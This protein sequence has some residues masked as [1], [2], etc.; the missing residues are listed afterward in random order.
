MTWVINAGE[1][2]EDQEQAFSFAQVIQA[3]SA[4]D[5]SW[6][7]KL[8]LND[9]TSILLENDRFLGVEYNVSG[10]KT[11][12]IEGSFENKIMIII[13]GIRHEEVDMIKITL[14]QILDLKWITLIKNAFIITKWAIFCTIVR[15]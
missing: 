8:G 14:D 7:D 1:K 15:R 10:D 3:G 6:K 9:V 2:I 13:I 5:T 12:V 11:L 4:N